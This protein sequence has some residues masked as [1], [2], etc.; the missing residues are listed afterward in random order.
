MLD[1]LPS[2]HSMDIQDVS[3]QLAHVHIYHHNSMLHL[4]PQS[5]CGQAHRFWQLIL[6]LC[7]LYISLAHMATI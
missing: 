3:I 6:M 2:E 1:L 5:T 7:H 4:S